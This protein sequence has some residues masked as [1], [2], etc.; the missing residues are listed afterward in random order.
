MILITGLGNPGIRYAD[1]RHNLGFRILDLL[2]GGADW[3]NKYESQ[4]IK[5]DDVI[6]A[7]P[8]T[9]MN[10]SGEA[11]KEILKYYPKADLVVVHDELDLPLGAI[12]IMKD[13]TSAGHNGVQSIIDELG[14]KNFIRVRLGTDNP[15]TRGQIP[16]DDYVL[17]NF[18]LEEEEIVKEVMKKTV[19]AIETIQTEG[20]EIAQAKF[21]G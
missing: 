8:Q 21:N 16:G 14:T 7:K 5:T 18:T 4:L 17:Q 11:V 15:Q 12:K 3:E 9:F 2:A 10:K 6:L 1:T 20:L 13:I 19:A